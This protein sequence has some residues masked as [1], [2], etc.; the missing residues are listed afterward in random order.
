MKKIAIISDTH[1]HYEK[2][3]INYASQCDEIWHAGDIGSLQLADDIAQIKPLRAVYG[4]IDGKDVRSEYSEIN[5]F[6]CEGVKVMIK[7]IVGYPGKYDLQMRELLLQH[8]PNLLVA[9]HSHICKVMYD[10]HYDLLFVN[11][12][13]LGLSGFHKV[14]TMVRLT[15]DNGAMKDCE[16]IELSK[17]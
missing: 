5:L 11:P 17:R 13:A 7:H 4:N 2:E 10:K 1:N 15:I 12:G 14:R 9:G 8:K 16:V 3:L 6:E